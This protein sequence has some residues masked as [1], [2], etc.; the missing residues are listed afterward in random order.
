MSAETVGIAEP[1]RKLDNAVSTIRALARE[2]F[3]LALA[4]FVADLSFALYLSYGIQLFEPDAVSRVAEAYYVFFSGDPHLG[5]IG[6]VWN[7]LPSVFVL[8]LVFAKFIAPSLVTRGIVA[9]VVTAVFGGIGAAQLCSI[10]EKLGFE[11]AWRL[12][13]AALYAVNPLILLYGADGLSDI[14]LMSSYLG[15][16]NGLLGY[17]RS[18]SLRALAAAGFWLAIGFGDRYEAVPFAAFAGIGLVLGL[19]GRRTWKE[20]GAA[21]ILLETPIVYAGAMWIYFNWLIMKDPLYFFNSPYGNAA[22]TSTGAGVDHA[23]EVARHNVMGTLSYAAHFLLLFWP[24]VLGLAA[25]L[26]WSVGRR[27][28]PI[29][30]VLVGA[31]AGSVTLEISLT[32]VGLLAYWERYFMAY[33]PLG[34]V[35]AAFAASKL[36][37]RHSRSSVWPGWVAPTLALILLAGNV[38]TLVAMRIPSLSHP[39]GQV[40]GHILTDHPMPPGSTFTYRTSVVAQYINAHPHLMVLM[41]TYTAYEVVMQV[42]NPRQLVITSDED[43]ASILS[44]PRGRVSAFLVPRPKGAYRLDAIDRRYPHLWAGKVKWTRLILAFNDPWHY[45]LY[46]IEPN[47]P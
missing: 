17:V 4:V 18:R 36:A 22:Q 47:A 30:P 23:L 6:M 1:V 46:Q 2:R 24:V 41:D 33:I 15:A 39:D 16:L 37:A 26:W 31:L 13:I 44:N 43:F 40:W 45:R 32:Y 28:D 5:A 11:K 10:L 19:A 21:L 42:K 25:A 35:M 7:P 9:D 3:L 8:P 29:A 27:R 34:F 14:I 38:G 12:T 20:I